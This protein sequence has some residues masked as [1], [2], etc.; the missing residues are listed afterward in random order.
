MTVMTREALRRV[1]AM[2][3]DTEQAAP[4]TSDDTADQGASVREHVR[5]VLLRLK[6]RVRQDRHR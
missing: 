4:G 6:D 1:R 2:P 5:S 3:A